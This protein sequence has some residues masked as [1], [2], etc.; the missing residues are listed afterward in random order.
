MLAQAGAVTRINW[1]AAANGESLCGI[2]AA[3]NSAQNRPD[4]RNQI[5]DRAKDKGAKG[6]FH[7]FDTLWNVAGRNRCGTSSK[8]IR[9]KISII[10]TRYTRRYRVQFPLRKNSDDSSNGSPPLW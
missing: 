2:G 4:Q 6:Q 1:R 7:G 8:K 9:C 5:G 10:G 3:R